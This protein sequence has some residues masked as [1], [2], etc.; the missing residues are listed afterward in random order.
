MI[1]SNAYRLKRPP[2]SSSH[3]PPHHTGECAWV[4]WHPMPRLASGASC[5]GAP[6]AVI[7]GAP[8]QAQGGSGLPN[9]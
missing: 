7:V 3:A 5:G 4:G 6:G 9:S 1:S 8:T 2:H